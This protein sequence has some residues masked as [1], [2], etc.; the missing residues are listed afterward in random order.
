MWWKIPVRLKRGRRLPLLILVLHFAALGG[1]GAEAV[2]Q[3][4]H[5]FVPTKV[6]LG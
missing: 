2:Q 6:S 1:S 4:H 3:D 5:L